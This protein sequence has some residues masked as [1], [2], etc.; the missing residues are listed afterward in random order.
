MV[1]SLKYH[2]KKLLKKVDFISWK[3]EN[4]IREIQ[5]IRKYHIKKRED[6]TK[7][8]KLCGMVRKLSHVLKKLDVNDEFRVE[9]SALLI[10]KLYNLGLI[11]SQKSLTLCEKL[12]ASTFCRRRLPVILVKLRMAPTVSMATT[13]IEHGHIRI[14]PEVVTDPALLVTRTMEDYVTWTDSSKIKKHLLRYQGEL[15]DFDVL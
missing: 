8:N 13:F 5:I 15:D 11:Q 14:G 6:Y 12:T 9:A 1:R 4:N 2:E 7:Y 3:K 10:E